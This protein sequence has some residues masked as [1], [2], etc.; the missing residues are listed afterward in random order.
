MSKLGKKTKREENEKK[1]NNEFCSIYSQKE[2]DIIKIIYKIDEGSK[3]IN[4]FNYS[5]VLEIKANDK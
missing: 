2:E 3:N 4:I 1:I 5:F